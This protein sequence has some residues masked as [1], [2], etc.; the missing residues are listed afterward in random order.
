MP[1]PKL[2]TAM[3]EIKVI[4]EKHD[5]GAIVL[6]S[7]QSH[8][9]YLRQFKTSWSCMWLEPGGLVRIRWKRAEF[10]NQ[11][12]YERA[13]KDT[14]GMIAGFADAARN[15]SDQMIKLLKV[16]GEKVKFSHF[17]REEPPNA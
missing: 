12:D 2:K 10:A 16:V 7:S 3:E 13:A 8:L 15:E 5:I 4:L 11:A 6:L 17:T 14:I 9:E 1:D